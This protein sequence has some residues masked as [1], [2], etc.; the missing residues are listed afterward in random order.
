MA[1]KCACGNEQGVGAGWNLQPAQYPRPVCGGL[2]PDD[3]AE[4]RGNEKR[5]GQQRTSSAHAR[6]KNTKTV[7]LAVVKNGRGIDLKRGSGPGRVEECR[8]PWC[9]GAERACW[10]S[11]ALAKYGCIGWPPA[12]AWV[13][14]ACAPAGP[15]RSL[16]AAAARPHTLI[17][18]SRS[19]RQFEKPDGSIATP[20]GSIAPQVFLSV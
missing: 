6:E 3:A 1:P 20:D 5:I 19:S 18:P 13:G 8:T 4:G 14:L 10:A 2:L 17:V 11:V 7:R 15:V 16:R 9:V 12:V